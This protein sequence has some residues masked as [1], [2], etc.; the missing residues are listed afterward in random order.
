MN[1]EELDIKRY[2]SYWAKLNG[3]EGDSFSEDALREL[4]HSKRRTQMSRRL[5]MKWIAF[6]VVLLLLLLALWG[7]NT[8][9]NVGNNKGIVLLAVVA[10]GLLV[11]LL[12]VGYDIYLMRRIHRLRYQ[13]LKMERYAERLHRITE[14]RWRRLQW[15]VDTTD[16]FRVRIYWRRMSGAIAC[17]V[18]LI[19]GGIGFVASANSERVLRACTHVVEIPSDMAVEGVL[20]NNEDGDAARYY[21]IAEEH[22]QLM[23][24][25][26]SI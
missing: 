2:Q 23:G 7:E 22:L 11:V 1:E 10:L 12:L 24:Q 16:Q 25:S 14:R 19:V 6:G 15:F 4:I 21:Q 3:G 18:L 8:M 5:R 17:V 9:L 26:V 13:T 20:C